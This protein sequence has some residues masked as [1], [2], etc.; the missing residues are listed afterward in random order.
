MAKLYLIPTTLSNQIDHS[1]VLPHQLILIK[2]LKYFIVETAKIGR[3]HIKYLSLDMP[4]QNLI[5]MELNKHTSN[6]ENLLQPLLDGYDVGLMSDCGMPCIADPGDIVVALSHTYNI[7][8]VPLFGSSSILLGLM[9]SGLNGQNFCFN[10][11]FPIEEAS[12]ITKIRQMNKTI[13]EDKQTQIFI[14]TP[15]RVKQLLKYFIDNLKNDIIL[16]LVVNLMQVD[17]RIIR[18]NIGEWK[19]IYSDFIIHKEEVIFILG[20]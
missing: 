3:Q 6:I 1:V 20:V 14:E 9:A 18:H 4:I 13:M 8:V 7:E 15:F 12:R 11:Y 19:I 10:G 16:V 2:H 5:I 17:Q